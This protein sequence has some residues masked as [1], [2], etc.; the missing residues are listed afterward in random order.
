MSGGLVAVEADPLWVVGGE[1]SYRS[2]SIRGGGGWKQRGTATT[3]GSRAPAIEPKGAPTP[4]RV[5]E[6]IGCECGLHIKVYIV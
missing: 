6:R 3:W 4:I 1:S 5:V 2:T